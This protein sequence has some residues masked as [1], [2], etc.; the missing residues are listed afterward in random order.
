MCQKVMS[1]CM[2]ATMF[3]KYMNTNK[4]ATNICVGT[5]SSGDK[6]QAKLH[7]HVC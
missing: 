6:V 4:A 2:I 5:I 3:V 1:S 7:A